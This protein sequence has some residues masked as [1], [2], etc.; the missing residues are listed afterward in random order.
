MASITQFKIR[1]PDD[2]HV[3]LRE[4]AMLENVL[5]H[6]A[7]NFARALVMPNLKSAVRVGIQAREYREKIRRLAEK[8]PF[9]PLM[10]IKLTQRTTAADIEDAAA[11]H[12]IAVKVYPEGVTTNS[13]DGVRDIEAINPDVFRAMVKEHVALCV[14]AEE[15]GVFS[16]DREASYL[17]HVRKIAE[18][19]P[20]LRIII[21]HITTAE[22]AKFVMEAGPNVAATIT[23]H[24]LLI[25][26]DDVVG[27]QGIRPHN[28][29]K[30][31]AKR[32]EDR[33]VLVDAAT[34]GYHR[35]FLGTDS[36]PHA[37]DTKECGRG[38]AGCFTAPIAMPLLAEL[39]D[40]R[41]SLDKLEAFTSENGANF[42]GLNLNK[43]YVTLERQ[44]WEVP[45]TYGS[46][47][48]FKAGEKLGWRV[49]GV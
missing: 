11:R 16:L 46:V 48:P 45:P 32:P 26:L 25:T 1:R 4:E 23:V 27:D 49:A 10:T 7:Q 13:E 37:K 18:A 47:V 9:E 12:A 21:E 41:D 24:H 40:K 29:C 6:T 39:F 3:H 8:T 2:F 30:P 22:A 20:D 43:D 31:I 17:T 35:F 36:A 42:Y 38:C 34:S 15:P 14:H 19:H 28:F 44:E 5:P 33:D